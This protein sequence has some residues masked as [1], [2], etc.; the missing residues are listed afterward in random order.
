MGTTI[1]AAAAA[2][3]LASALFIWFQVREMKKQT[4][5][6][7]EIAEAAA[8]PYIWA[9][10]RVQ[11]ANGWNLEFAIG[12]SG[13]TVAR[14]VVVTVDPPF[15][16][17]D[18]TEA[19]YVQAMHERLERGLPSVAPG[20]QYT[21]T[22]GNSADLVNRPAPLA[23]TVTI[24]CSGPAGPT[25]R[26]QFTI[27]FESFRES[28]ARH[29]GS[30]RDI[31]KEI[32]VAADKLVHEQKR[33]SSAFESLSERLEPRTFTEVARSTADRANA[34][35]GAVAV[36]WRRIS[37]TSRGALPDTGADPRQA[38]MHVMAPDKQL[39]RLHRRLARRGFRV[40]PSHRAAG[41]VHVR[42]RA[43]TTDEQIVR[44][45]VAKAA[46]DGRFGPP[47]APTVHLDGYRDQC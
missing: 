8:A 3:T 15:P 6:Q 14:D 19:R 20:R 35:M 29:D 10:V 17:V 40:G 12:N 37:S 18:D 26:S 5:L 28:V 47:G 16:Q 27:D 11:A 25:A 21:W 42:V 39:A 44:D 9:D 24:D 43:G 23:H 30:L 22:L 41:G 32:R 4:N 38:F 2:A 36:R 45:L 7:R 34:V 31:A 13:P 46:P 1:A 33:Q